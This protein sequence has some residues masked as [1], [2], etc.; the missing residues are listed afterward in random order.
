MNT[1]DTLQLR[2]AQESE[3]IAKIFEAAIEAVNNGTAERKDL[4]SFWQTVAFD[5]HIINPTALLEFELSRRP[6]I[7]FDADKE[8]DFVTRL[9]TMF[10]WDKLYRTLEE[11]VEKNLRDSWMIEDERRRRWILNPEF[12]TQDIPPALF[13]F[14][15]R[16]AIADNKWGPQ[17]S[18][19]T[20]QIFDILEQL[21]SDLPE[22]YRKNG[23]GDLPAELVSAT[24][25]GVTVTASDITA[26]IT[27]EIT[28]ESANAYADAIRHITLLLSTTDFPH[29]YWIQYQ[30]PGDA[31]LP[32]EDL[33]D[34]AVHRLFATAAE[35]PEL[36]PLI[37]SYA[38]A[39]I[40]EF[41]WYTDP[42][43]DA[44]YCALPGTFAVFALAWADQK[45]SPTLIDYLHAVDGEHQELHV[46][47]VK[48]YLLKYGP[49]PESLAALCIAIDNCQEIEPDERLPRIVANEEALKILLTFLGCPQEGVDPKVIE[50]AAQLGDYGDTDADSDTHLEID[51]YY[52]SEVRYTLWGRD[53]VNGGKETLASAPEELRP[54]Y[55]KIFTL[56]PPESDLD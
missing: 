32:I 41:E 53:G 24:Y 13:D 36:H 39:A 37:E 34:I 44:E 8:W 23:S 47:F 22:H 5:G 17:Y 3:E 40:K 11:W 14:A 27:V 25:K 29:S 1:D 55:E 2:H 12:N 31:L 48:E 52:L 16:I 26:I 21:G 33:P 56:E 6:A 45:Y 19:L 20:S 51:D 30:G 54:L 35:Y 18:G 46:F 38:H 50:L 10:S 49:T 7:S 9:I 28:E 43:C 42:A 4:S 15:C